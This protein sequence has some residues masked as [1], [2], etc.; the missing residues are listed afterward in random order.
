MAIL[1][2]G[3]IYIPEVVTDGAITR[4]HRNG[5]E[6][7]ML[8]FAIDKQN[9]DSAGIH[10]LGDTIKQGCDY[11]TRI[12]A[13]KKM[14]DNNSVTVF[15]SSTNPEECSK[16]GIQEQICKCTRNVD[17]NGLFVLYLSGH[18]LSHGFLPGDYSAGELNSISAKLLSN[19]LASAWSSIGNI[20]VIL[21][22]CMAG[23]LAKKLAELVPRNVWILSACTGSETTLTS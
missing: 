9:H 21:D 7:F 13:A 6:S 4:Q 10:S 2:Q 3:S 16:K 11:I 20:L 8:A 23:M 18:G 15:Q 12:F 22:C 19:C 14:V 17:E 1:Q 5:K